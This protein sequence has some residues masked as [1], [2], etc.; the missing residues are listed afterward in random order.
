MSHAKTPRGAA[1][2]A[3]SAQPQGPALSPLIHL[4]PYAV[5]PFW[6]DTL[7]IMLWLWRRQAGKSF[8]AACLALRRMMQIRGLSAF[9]VSASVALGIEFI[10]KE[11]TVWQQVL[12]KF[13]EL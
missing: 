2:S 4:R 5:E 11:A 8:H 12:V 7:G 13:R 1:P 10:R 3:S 6:N 9:F